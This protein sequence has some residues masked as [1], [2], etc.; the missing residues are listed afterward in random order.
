MARLVT[1]ESIDLQSRKIRELAEALIAA[2]YVGLDD[3][4]SAFGLPRSTTWTILHAKHKNSGLSAS[5]IRRMLPQP[6][7]PK[8]VR[9]KLLQYVEQK[10]SG[11][12]GHTPQQVRRFAAGLVG[13]GVD[14]G[15]D[16]DRRSGQPGCDAIDPQRNRPARPAGVIF[17]QH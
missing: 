9:R 3:Q 6:R 11:A 4:A 13:F 1:R 16:I 15:A 12:Y 5:V 2:G 7:L 17:E 14:G 8:L 10:S